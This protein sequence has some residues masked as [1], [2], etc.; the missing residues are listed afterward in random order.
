MIVKLPHGRRNAE[1]VRRRDDGKRTIDR[2]T[3]PRPGRFMAFAP[4][5]AGTLQPV[6]RL[7]ELAMKFGRDRW[8]SQRGLI[9][10]QRQ[11][12]K[13]LRMRALGSRAPGIEMDL[14]PVR[15]FPG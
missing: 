10:C 9:T 13:T 5:A 15:P 14:I 6:L 1:R 11:L 12:L 4:P 8:L 7:R 3:D 2:K